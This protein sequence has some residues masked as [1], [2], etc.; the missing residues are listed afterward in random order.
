LQLIPAMP[1]T[2]EVL[3]Q[4]Y[5]LESGY[6]KDSLLF[7]HKEGH[8]HV[9]ESVT[10]L[11][12]LWRDRQISRFV[13]DTQDKAGAVLPERQAVVLEL[14]GKG[15]LRTAERAIL[16]QLPEQELQ[17]LLQRGQEQQKDKSGQ[18]NVGKHRPGTLVR[19]EIDGVDLVQRQVSVVKVSGF[20]PSRTRVWADPWSRIVFQHL[21]RNGQAQCIS[22]Q[23]L[24]Q[25]SVG[26]SVGAAVGEVK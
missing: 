4:A 6:S 20:V 23:T 22:F 8:Y 10:P 1:V 25:T 11:A 9:S 19:V 18:G 17:E 21:H 3:S 5:H 2:P 7:L 12:L 13:V 26:R 16:A 15:W 14:R 24:M